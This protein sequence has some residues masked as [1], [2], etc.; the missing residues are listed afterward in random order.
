MSLSAE[1]HALAFLGLWSPM[2]QVS[3]LPPASKPLKNQVTLASFPH[4]NDLQFAGLTHVKPLF[5]PKKF[6]IGQD[7]VISSSN[8]NRQ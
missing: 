5:R 2:C 4:D 3:T 8:V 7:D 6:T 1:A